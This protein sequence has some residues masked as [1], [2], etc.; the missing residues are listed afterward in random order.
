M[1]TLASVTVLLA[2]CRIAAAQTYSIPEG[3]TVSNVEA[4]TYDN[5][6]GSDGSTGRFA[7][8]G[9][10]TQFVYETPAGKAQ[11]CNGTAVWTTA[12]VTSGPYTGDTFYVMNCQASPDGTSHDPATTIHVEITAHSTTI[13]THCGRWRCTV[14]Q[15]HVN[16]G[17]VTIGWV[18]STAS[19]EIVGGIGL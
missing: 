15:W 11:Y 19:G 16:E 8:G 3:T 5:L 4:W 14:T 17:M 1:K 6:A 13:Q 7:A 12:R 2:L 10:W 9:Y 18:P